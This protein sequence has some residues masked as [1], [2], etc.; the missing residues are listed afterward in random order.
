MGFTTDIYDDVDQQNLRLAAADRADAAR[1]EAANLRQ[2]VPPNTGERS[3][4]FRS[5]AATPGGVAERHFSLAAAA[6]KE[7]GAPTSFNA[8]AGAPAPIGVIRGTT[9]TYATDTGGPQPQE[10]ATPLQARQAFNRAGGQGEYEPAEG[11]RLRIAAD[12]YNKRPDLVAQARLVAEKGFRDV[13]TERLLKEYGVEDMEKGLVLPPAIQR[14]ALG[15][16]PQSKEEVEGILQQIAPE[17]GKIK[18]ANLWNDPK[19]GMAMRRQLLATTAD[20]AEQ[21]RIKEEVVT[22]KTLEWFE[23]RRHQGQPP[24]KKVEPT[25]SVNPLGASRPKGSIFTEP[26]G[27][28]DNPLREAAKLPFAIY[29]NILESREDEAGV[30]LRLRR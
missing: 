28:S 22:P 27:S 19:T 2:A 13:L 16:R 11:P 8:G 17:G 1:T 9:S 12:V 14:L 5:G 7:L 25:F 20:P 24:P 18:A 29:R 3:F 4:G 30:P 26:L 21:K 6:G 15:H 10:F 23:G